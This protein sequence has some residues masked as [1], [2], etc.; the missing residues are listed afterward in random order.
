MNDNDNK[1][2]NEKLLINTIEENVIEEYHVI[3]NT[4][5]FSQ[6]PTGYI[7][8]TVLSLE[9]FIS[10]SALGVSQT[11]MKVFVLLTAILTH[12]WA[13]SFALCILIIIKLDKY[14][15]Y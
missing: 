12:I 2:E 10:G 1:I 11:Y 5:K 13:E 8:L 14:L 7:L 6:H 9:S 3:K 4:K 15:L